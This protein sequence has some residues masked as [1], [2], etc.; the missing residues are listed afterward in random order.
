MKKLKRGTRK[1]KGKFPLI[2]YSYGKIGHF[3]NKCPYS[4]KEES[5]DEITFKY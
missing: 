2:C 1:Y 3:T 5:D 4:K